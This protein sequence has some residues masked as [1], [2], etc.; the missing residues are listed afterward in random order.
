MSDLRARQLGLA[1]FGEFDL[2]VGM[3]SENLDNIHALQPPDGTARVACLTDYVMD[4]DHV[5]DPYFT[6]DFDGALSLIERCVDE[7]IDQERK[8]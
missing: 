5:P 8:L 7:L 4:A 1:D 2:I 3:D 6:R